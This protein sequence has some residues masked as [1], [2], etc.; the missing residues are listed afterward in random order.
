LQ[1]QPSQSP[2]T[3]YLLLNPYTNVI[4]QDHVSIAVPIRDAN[5]S[6]IAALCAVSLD[7]DIQ[8]TIIQVEDLCEAAQ[9]FSCYIC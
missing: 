7:G 1:L 5:E 2:H 8:E 4:S 9:Q 3:R 6:L